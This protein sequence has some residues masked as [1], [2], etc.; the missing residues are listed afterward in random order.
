[1]TLVE[2][3]LC[4]GAPGDPSRSGHRRLLGLLACGDACTRT[5]EHDAS[6]PFDYRSAHVDQSCAEAAEDDHTPACAQAARDDSPAANNNDHPQTAKAATNLVLP[7][8][9]ICQQA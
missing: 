2:R 6:G 8:V 1:M 4:A 5:D 7:P 3:V 9:A